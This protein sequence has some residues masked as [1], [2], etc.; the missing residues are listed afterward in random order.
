MIGLVVALSDEARRL[1]PGLGLEPVGSHRGFACYQSP[2]LVMVV[3]GAGGERAG[4]ACRA[5]LEIF[6]PR[7]VLVA[8]L[9][10]GL[11]PELETGDLLVGSAVGSLR[12]PSGLLERALEWCPEAIRADLTSSDQVLVTVAAKAALAH[13]TGAAAVDMESQAVAEEAA[14]AGVPWLAL[15]AISDPLDNPLPLDFNRYLGPDGQPSLYR[16]GLAVLAR[17]H[18]V[19][20]MV[21]LGRAAERAGQALEGGLKRIVEGLARR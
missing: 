20:G 15:R 3:S 19:P 8:G 12:P 7:P 4:A 5:L 9:S 2:E 14:R 21:A 18:L 10:G 17:P 1:R 13:Q 6:R 11:A 16:L